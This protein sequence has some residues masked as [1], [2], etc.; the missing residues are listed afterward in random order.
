[1]AA[2]IPQYSKKYGWNDSWWESQVS[3][4]NHIESLIPRNHRNNWSIMCWNPLQLSTPRGRLIEHKAVCVRRNNISG[5]LLTTFHSSTTKVT[6]AKSGMDLKQAAK[7]RN[8]LSRISY[9][10]HGESKGI[11]AWYRA[12]SLSNMRDGR[13]SGY[14]I[15][16]LF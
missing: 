5:S 3:L 1:M 7:E 4:W 10:S 6:Y 16:R 12:E 11:I 9:R 2:D 15:S 8:D 13:L 14:Y